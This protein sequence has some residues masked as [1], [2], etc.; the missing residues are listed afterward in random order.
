VRRRLIILVCALSIFGMLAFTETRQIVKEKTI[1]LLFQLR[2]SIQPGYDIT[3]IAIDENTLHSLGAWPFPRRYHAQLLERLGQAKAIGFD[4]LFVEPALDDD[5][6][7][8]A[9][10]AGPP[11]ILAATHTMENHFLIPP[12]SVQGHRGIG[13]IQVILGHGGIVRRVV[14]KDRHGIPALSKALLDST[15]LDSP[16]EKL[17]NAPLINFYGPRRTF[18]TLS[19]LDVLEGEVPVDLLKGRYILVGLEAT[20]TGDNCFAPFSDTNMLSGVEIQATI[21]QNLLDQSFLIPLTWLVWCFLGVVIILQLVVWPF[22]SEIKILCLNLALSLGLFLTALHLFQNNYL[23]NFSLVLLFLFISWSIHLLFQGI[24][25]TGYIARQINALDRE[26]A[27]DLYQAF[28]HSHQLRQELR[29]THSSGLLQH[30][31]RLEQCVAALTLQHNFIDRLLKKDMLPLVLWNRK[32]GKPILF[33][34]S[35]TAFWHR[36]NSDDEIAAPDLQRFRQFLLNSRLDA[37][38]TGTSVNEQTALP[39]NTTIDIVLPTKRESH[40]YQV[41]LRTIDST[42]REEFQGLLSIFSDVTKIRKLERLKDDTVSFVSHELRRPL[43][44]IRGYAEM[45]V[46][47]LDARQRLYAETISSQTIRLNRLITAFLDITRLQQGELH[48]R[49]HPINL[50]SL[51]KEA[52]ATLQEPAREKNISIHTILPDQ[53]TVTFS[54]DETLLQQALI[55]LL[56]NSIKFS[57]AGNEILVRLQE[58]PDHFLITIQD[59]GPG[60]PAEIRPYIFNAFFRGD[61]CRSS[62]GFGLG[63]ALVDQVVRAHDGKIT[64]DDTD[65]GCCF[66]ISLP[67]KDELPE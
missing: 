2:G 67:K 8:A 57:S 7:S 44:T 35:F 38:K 46:D 39:E 13:H 53:Q 62:Q 5:L 29:T 28:A 65:H 32:D 25:T 40:Y 1:D 10:Q 36:Y 3:I 60:I 64:L 15:T 12:Q 33:S 42:G 48:V 55:N 14:L 66:H 18:T 31:N 52:I 23:F 51:I 59:H 47:T 56:E 16:R 19:Y 24:W 22:L 17:P 20:G 9:L 54:G 30:V 11:V 50:A 58:F 49:S 61:Q 21:L 43:T 26:L 37:E 27:N 6:L 45:L 63:L 34:E 41:T 4:I